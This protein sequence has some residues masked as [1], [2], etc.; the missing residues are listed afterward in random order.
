[1]FARSKDKETIAVWIFVVVN[2]VSALL[3]AAGHIPATVAMFGGLNTLVLVRCF[4]LNGISGMVFGWL[5]QKLGLQYAMMAHALGHAF[6]HVIF[7]YFLL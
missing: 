7:V 3:F 6:H 5:Y 1:M 4:L 2:S